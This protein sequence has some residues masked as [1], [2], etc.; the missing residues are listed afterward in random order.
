[1][2]I[3][4]GPGNLAAAFYLDK[5]LS[6]AQVGAKLAVDLGQEFFLNGKLLKKC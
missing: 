6:V 2:F 3:V 4:C 1:M 5:K